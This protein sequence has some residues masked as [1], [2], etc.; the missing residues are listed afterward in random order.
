[1]LTPR[2]R[3]TKKQ[4][5]ED[6]FIT[7]SVQARDWIEENSRIVFGGIVVLVVILAAVF[8]INNMRVK[9]EMTASAELANAM[10]VFESRD[11]G[12]SVALFT[13]IVNSAGSTKSGRTA[14]FFLA[15]SLYN[16][17]EYA[18]AQEHFRK[19]ASSCKE[20]DYLRAAALAGEAG[21][22]EQQ[23][24]FSQAAEKYKNI[25]KKF[26]PLAARYL[27]RA[28]RCYAQAGNDEQAKTIYQQ[29]IDDYPNSQEKSDALLYSS[30][31]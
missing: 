18:A 27:L 8:I 21:C 31:N 23:N 29:I 13:G 28:A 20:D 14:R 11:Y 26:S 16:T 4:L 12:N 3:I 2:K 19:F 15:Q 9:A 24:Q 30:M 10:R 25:A 7:Y 1:M 5:K 17:D 22:L 6:K